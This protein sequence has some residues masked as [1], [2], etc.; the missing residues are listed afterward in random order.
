MK[1]F[2]HL[3]FYGTPEFA[4]PSLSAI[5]EAGY[6]VQAV[7]TAPDRPA[8]RGLRLLSTPV[9]EFARSKN[10]PV[11][12]PVNLRDPAFLG[13]LRELNPDL[14]VVIAFRMMPRE[15][16]SLPRLGTFNLH[17]SLLP[18]YRGAAPINRAVMNGETD[19]GLTTFLLDE[20]IDTGC[21]LL[22][23]RVSIGGDETAG[24]LH[25]RMMLLGSELVLKTI[26]RI[27][28]GERGTPQESMTEGG[29]ELRKAP[30][31]FRE[32]CRIDWK[33]DTLRI[34]N[35]IRGLS[36]VPA[37]WTQ[38]HSHDGAIH[39]L[40]ILRALPGFPEGA[41]IPGTFRITGKDSL[42]IATGN[43]C[44]YVKE[45]QLSGRKPLNSVDFVSG[46]G[47]IFPETLCL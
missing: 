6:P 25:D 23:E 20:R 44:I 16:W 45:L 40:K 7:V 46:Y 11:L 2:P 34:H 12:E 32:D 41:G 21:I 36:P 27:L 37:A 15:V 9:K 28:Q 31:I 18:Q 39:T 5:V 33:G 10:L 13:T 38:L 43:G 19:T 3:I 30:K 4:V 8:G 29:I 17:A 24:A 42:T 35:F 14:Q 22:Q 1:D 47:R 26:E